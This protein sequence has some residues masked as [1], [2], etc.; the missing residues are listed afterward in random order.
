MLD[1]T[2]GGDG[3]CLRQWGLTVRS[4]ME[5]RKCRGFIVLDAAAL[6]QGYGNLCFIRATGGSP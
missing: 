1:F 5:G 4:V 6:R 3:R 2:S